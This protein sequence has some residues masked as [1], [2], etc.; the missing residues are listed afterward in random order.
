[1]ETPSTY[2]NTPSAYTVSL[3]KGVSLVSSYSL[4]VQFRKW[5]EIDDTGSDYTVKIAYSGGGD[6]ITTHTPTFG[7]S[8]IAASGSYKWYTGGQLSSTVSGIFRLKV[9]TQSETYY[10]DWCDP[11]GFTDKIKISLSSSYDYGRI[12]YVGGYEQWMYK[13]ATVRRAPKAEIEITGD[14]L[15]GAIVEEKKTT[16]I[17]YKI[18]MK[19]TESEYEGLVHAMGGTLEIT[20]QTG[21]TYDAVNIELSDPTWYRA[22][23][24]IELSFID[25]N[26]INVWTMNNSN[27]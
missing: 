18:T 11:C 21:K 10:S 19:C 17:R 24:V 23:G 26:N 27:L 7:D 16:A 22:N 14:K 13:N 9:A 1:M 4:T 3:Y 12:K 2:Y 8:T 5:V 20:D 15:N 25:D 6:S